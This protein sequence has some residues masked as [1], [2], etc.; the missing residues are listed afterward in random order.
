MYINILGSGA[1]GSFKLTK[2]QKAIRKK[3]ES[4]NTKKENQSAK[5]KVKLKQE[6]NTS[7]IISQ[8]KDD[9]ELVKSKKADGKKIPLSKGN[10]PF[11]VATKF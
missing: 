6:K 10:F 1:N 3:S 4:D 7:K 5:N 11:W 8:S 2:V 9:M